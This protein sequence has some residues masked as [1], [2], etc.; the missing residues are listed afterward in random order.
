MKRADLTN[1]RPRAAE[2]NDH[3]RMRRTCMACVA[4]LTIAP[5]GFAAN[6]YP[7]GPVQLVVPFTAGS[8]SDLVARVFGQGLSA[9]LG[10]PVVINNRPGA[11]GTIAAGAVAKAEPD[12]QTL[13]VVGMGH[14]ANPALYKSLPYDT[15]KDFAA[16]A[17]LATF[18][19]VLVVPANGNIKTAQQLIAQAKANPGQLNYSSGGIGSAAHINMQLLLEAA[20]ITAEHIPLKGA[21]EIVTEIA[22]GRCQVG[23]APLGAALQMIRV[24]KVTALAISAKTRS[25]LLPDVPTIAEAGFPAAEFNVWVGVLAPAKTRAD[26][27][28]LLSEQIRKVAT[29]PAVAEK[30][31]MVGAEPMTLTPAQF[32]ALMRKDYV[33]LDRLM[34]KAS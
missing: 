11:G 25:K 13:A 3:G 30:L 28:N 31:A 21:S 6:K 33:I 12:G 23:W 27:V 24:G 32:E 29:D 22:A 1:P 7:S 19:N 5:R 16:V 34:R 17:P 2:L 15:M 4:G 18:A 20:G 8:G 10:Q 14:L 9:G 26:V